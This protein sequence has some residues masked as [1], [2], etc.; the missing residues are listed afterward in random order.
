V[1]FHENT[2]AH[3]I[4]KGEGYR[5]YKRLKLGG[6]QILIFYGTVFIWRLISGSDYSL[7]ME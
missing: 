5:K 2:N 6:G 3:D 7:A 4:G 1:I